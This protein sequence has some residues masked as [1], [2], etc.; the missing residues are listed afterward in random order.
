MFWKDK[1]WA[2]YETIQSDIFDHTLAIAPEFD[3]KV[4]KSPAGSDFKEFVAKKNP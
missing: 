2:N 1:V 3:L 4:F